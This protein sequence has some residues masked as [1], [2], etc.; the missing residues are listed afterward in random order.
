[1]RKRGRERERGYCFFFCVEGLKLNG[2]FGDE[3]AT[4]KIQST[5][6]E[7]FFLPVL[8]SLSLS[9]SLPFSLFYEL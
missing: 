6:N 1:M 8:K 3:K 2:C 4:L 7:D 5:P 9:L